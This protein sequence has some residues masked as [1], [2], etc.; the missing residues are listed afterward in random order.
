MRHAKRFP[1]PLVHRR[2]GGINAEV[3]AFEASCPSSPS[4]TS[5]TATAETWTQ[6]VEAG[7]M[8]DPSGSEASP[9]TYT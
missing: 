9:T 7:A 4:P 5:P 2:R 6:P 1:L 8:V 3:G